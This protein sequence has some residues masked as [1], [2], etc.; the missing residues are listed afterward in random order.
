[1]HLKDLVFCSEN[2]SKPKLGWN[3]P[4]EIQTVKAKIYKLWYWKALLWRTLQWNH[5]AVAALGEGKRSWQVE[6]AVLE[7]GWCYSKIKTVREIWLRFNNPTPHVRFV[8]N[9]KERCMGQA[10]KARYLGFMPARMKFLLFNKPKLLRSFFNRYTE[11]SIIPISKLD[12][13]LYL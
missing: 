13:S 10:R 7:H 2:N 5:F 1:M 9:E 4:D 3:N 8:P 6:A 11:T 12:N